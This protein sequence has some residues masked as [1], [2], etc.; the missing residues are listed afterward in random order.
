M[1][2]SNSWMINGAT[3]YTR[4]FD[5]YKDTVSRLF[6]ALSRDNVDAWSI[7][8]VDAFALAHFLECYPRKV[9][10]LEIGTFVGVSAFHFASQPQVLR[11]VSVDP[12]PTVADEIND[13]AEVVDSSRIDASSLRNIKVLDVAQETLAE[14]A[15]EQTKIQLHVGTVGSTRM[16]V[17][18]DSPEASETVEVPELAEGESLLAFVD[19][20]HTKEGVQADL[21]AIFEKNPRA[22]AILDDCRQAWGPFVQAGVVSFLEAAGRKYHFRLFG[23]L[24]PGL[25]TS[26]LGIVYPDTDATETEQTLVE[27]SELFTERLD[28]LRLLRREEELIEIINGF[29]RELKQAR[30]EGHESIKERNARLKE[31]NEELKRARTQVKES[32]ARLKERNEELK[33]VRTELAKAKAS[34]KQ[35]ESASQLKERSAHLEKCNAQLSEQNSQLVTHYSSQRYKLADAVVESTLMVPGIKTLLRRKQSK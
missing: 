29:D 14:F 9:I 12:N 27:L 7:S 13:K 30:A 16:G 22:I 28:P 17:R 15:D 18:P 26:N 19:G 3:E 35:S 20:L 33:R 25:A 24:G 8:N 23:D 6:P 5:E 1:D 10:V 32:H 11:V 2:V 34:D 4:R 31:R 21:E